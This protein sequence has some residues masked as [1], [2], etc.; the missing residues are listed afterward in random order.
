MKIDKQY[1]Q[2]KEFAS[3]RPRTACKRRMKR[4]GSW[5]SKN[6]QPISH[7]S[8]QKVYV[9]LSQLLW[10]FPFQRAAEAER[11]EVV[12]DTQL[13]STL[14]LAFLANIEWW[15]SH[16]LAVLRA[17]SAWI[18]HAGNNISKNMFSESALL[19]PYNIRD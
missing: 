7:I 6:D 10:C 11:S 14:V 2:R 5:Y 12:S 18:V 3:G 17:K 19:M 9:F 8:Q 16:L 15:K 4:W 13:V 1:Q